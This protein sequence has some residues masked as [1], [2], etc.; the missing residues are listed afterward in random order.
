MSTPTKTV[1]LNLS[2][3]VRA[4]ILLNLFKGNLDDL[5]YILDDVKLVKVTE[6]EWIMAERQEE[7]LSN[8]DKQWRWTDEKVPEKAI[9]FQKE[10]VDYLR[11]VI[12]EKNKAG[13]FG[14]GD[15][16][17]ISLRKKFI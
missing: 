10:S 16:A 12:D 5:S 3:R 8:G 7:T 6:E 13:E 1:S 14:I 4:G 2:E 17:Y 11:K 9:E 15:E